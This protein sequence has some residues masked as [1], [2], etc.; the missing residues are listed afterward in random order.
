MEEILYD[1]IPSL[2]LE[3][4][5]NGDQRKKEQFVS[6]LGTAF[7]NIGFVAVRN[8]FLSDA[9]RDKLYGAT[10]KFF[11]LPDDV[12]ARYEISGLAGQRGYTGK[13][14][15]HAKGR[16]TG[17]LKEFYHIG[18]EL[19]TSELSSEGYPANIWP[20]EVPGFKEATV[21]AYRSLAWWRTRR[22]RCC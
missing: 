2:D 12:K 21:E 4:F 13:G 16:N 20:A 6:R 17:D 1:E 10:R 22:C 5:Y 11:S 19:S 18:Q 8:H 15:E 14:K 7:H 9:L 3:N